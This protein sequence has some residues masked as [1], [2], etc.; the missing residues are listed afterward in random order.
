MIINEQVYQ[1]LPEPLKQLTDL[2]KDRER[3]IV[4]LSCL[5]VLS[6]CLPKVYG[7]YGGSKVY[8][9]LYFFIVAPAAS[10]KGAVKYAIGLVKSIHEKIKNDSEQEAKDCK[11]NKDIDNDDCPG[12]KYKII[13]GNIKIYAL[14]HKLYNIYQIDDPDSHRLIF[15]SFLR[16]CQNSNP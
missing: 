3:D 6:G 7:I 9:N 15:H 5:G 1:N 8:S 13:A 12:I 2:F 4:L 16:R 10:G 14:T 11:K